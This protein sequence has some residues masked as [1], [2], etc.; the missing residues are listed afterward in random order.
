MRT[1]AIASIITL[2]S[3]P[4]QAQSLTI[5]GKFGYLGEYELLA[6]V[7][8]QASGDKTEYSGPMIVRHVGLC[9]HNGPNESN[10]EIKLHFTNVTPRIVATL[11]YDGHEC[12]YR[13]RMSETDVGQLICS[14]DALPI[15]IWS[16]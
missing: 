4:A 10:G 5:S 16:K 6:V 8:T 11:S 15:S 2:F 14:G 1:F 7:T 9:S 13:G 3:L 12:A